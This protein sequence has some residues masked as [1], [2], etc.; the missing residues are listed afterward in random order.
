M[1]SSARFIRTISRNLV[2]DCEVLVLHYLIG[3][4]F[5][6]AVFADEARRLVSYYLG[7]DLDESNF[8]IS[9]NVV[10]GFVV[11]LSRD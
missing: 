2:K 4:S 9:H 7:G 5:D 3:V 11:N 8:T 6:L 10:I 1:D